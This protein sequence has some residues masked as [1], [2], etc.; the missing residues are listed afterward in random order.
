MGDAIAGHDE[1][2]P[3]YA[4]PPDG[5]SEYGEPFDAVLRRLRGQYQIWAG[6]GLT[7]DD[8]MADFWNGRLWVLVDPGDGVR[9]RQGLPGDGCARADFTENTWEVA[10]VWAGCG[11]EFDNPYVRNVAVSEVVSGELEYPHEAMNRVLDALMSL[12]GRGMPVRRHDKRRRRRA[13]PAP[14]R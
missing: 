5:G 14:P 3:V 4:D 9:R 2:F 12:L 10:W 13:R 8:T 7:P 6:L 1:W 11:Q